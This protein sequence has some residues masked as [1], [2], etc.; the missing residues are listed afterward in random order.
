MASDANP[1][2]AAGPEPAPQP[3][4]PARLRALVTGLCVLYAAALVGL[5]L[6]LHLASDRWWGATLILYG[7]RW[8]CVLPL[9]VLLPAAAVCRRRL[10]ALLAAVSV[11]LLFPLMGLCVPWGSAFRAACR[12]PTVRVLT[13]N[14]HGRDLD[15][16]PL[17]A[18]IDSTRPD[19]VALQSWSPRYQS[20]VF[21]SADWH[22]WQE[23][24]LC[25]A[26]RHSIR[27]GELLDDPD[28]VHTG[29]A[30][31]RFDVETPAGEVVFVCLHLASPRDGLE[32][33]IRSRGLRGDQLQANS[34]LRRRQ[35][36]KV[37]RWLDPTAGPL[38]LAGDFNTPPE[39]ATYREWW[40]RYTN[41]FSAAGLGFG[42][43]HFTRRTGVRIDHVLAGPG[44]HCERCW[45]APGVGSPHHPVIADLCRDSPPG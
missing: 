5:C 14:V 42:P 35:S 28:F 38:L 8:L 13:C 2:S 45:V 39:S 41:G 7:P 32:E 10:L 40:S 3:R 9:A 16:A 17:A 11:A 12:G 18:L 31:A 26:S 6:L 23:G 27:R 30:A 24:Q 20:A 29:S 37:V 15:P 36:E 33:V 43:T 22:V 1:T 19:V 34:D 44:W 4:W 21:P 25:L